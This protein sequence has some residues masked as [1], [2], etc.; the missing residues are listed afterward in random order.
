MFSVKFRYA[1]IA[2]TKMFPILTKI[3][4]M[5]VQEAYNFVLY[6]STKSARFILKILKSG[7]AN[8]RVKNFNVTNLYI[9]TA[10]ANRASFVKRL[11]FCARGRNSTILK[12]SCHIYIEL[13]KIV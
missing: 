3:C 2:C 6:K 13:D 12:K 11:R 5:R 10:V 8:A 4:G 7:I 1:H 9:K